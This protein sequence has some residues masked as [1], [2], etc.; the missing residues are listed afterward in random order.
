MIAEL[1]GG[2]IYTYFW[3][4]VQITLFLFCADYSEV[5][6]LVVARFLCSCSRNMHRLAYLEVNGFDRKNTKDIK[7]FVIAVAFVG[8]ASSAHSHKYDYTHAGSILIKSSPA[9]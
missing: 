3:L 6:P 1:K 9:E 5:P 7:E 4:R 2:S 8:S